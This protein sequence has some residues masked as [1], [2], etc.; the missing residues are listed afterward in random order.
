MSR[1]NLFETKYNQSNHVHVKEMLNIYDECFFSYIDILK[2]KEVEVMSKGVVDCKCTS[3]VHVSTYYDKCDK[4]NGKGHLHING[5]EVVCN[6][7]YGKKR[8][9][10]NVCPLCKGEGEVVGDKKVMV[11]LDSS[12]KEGDVITLEGMGQESNGVKGDLIIKV[13]IGDYDCF[14]I[15]GN[16]VYDRRLI[17]FSKEDIAKSVS[18]KIETI[19]GF[20]FV[21]SK[22]EEEKEIVKLEKEG[23]NGGDFYVC[24]HNELTPIRGK[25]V[26]KNIIISKEEKGFYLDKK[27]LISDIK[28][29]TSNYYKRVHDVDFEYVELDDVNNFKVVKL[30]RKGLDGKYGGERGDLY[31]RVFFDDEFICRNDELYHLPINLNK[32]EIKDGKKALEFEKNKVV[33]TFEKN[34]MDIQIIDVEDFGFM[35]NNKMFDSCKFIVSPFE[36]KVYKVS[37]RV[38]KKDKIIYIKDYKKYFFEEISVKK[39]GLKVTLGKGKVTEV[40]DG[41]GN[42]VIIRVIREE[43]FSWGYSLILVK[44]IKVSIESVLHHLHFISG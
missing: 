1:G 4:C 10:K 6:R 9:I 13:R 7:C 23:V 44:F 40:F 11:K 34:L 42:K 15:K 25:D 8:V 30:K 43:V 5:N 20:T 18:K 38:K 21:A 22:G 12:L 26:Y 14:D 41:E 36:Y 19:K 16:D 2:G 17:K 35:I 32:Y 3:S 28:C 37:V 27:E 33:L 31:L 24:L 39:D 29:L